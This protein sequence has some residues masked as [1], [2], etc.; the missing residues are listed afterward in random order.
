MKYI[1]RANKKGKAID[2]TQPSSKLIA[3]R[4]KKFLEKEMKKSKSTKWAKNIRIAKI[5]PP[6][7]K[8]ARKKAKK[9]FNSFW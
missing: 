4:R 7:P 2:V 8:K 3:L 6:S 9:I 5:R 1:V